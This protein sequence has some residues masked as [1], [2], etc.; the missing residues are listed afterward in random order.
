MWVSVIKAIHGHV[1]NLDHGV[2]VRKSSIWLNCIRCSSNLK[3]RGVDL[4]MC[5]K[6]KVGNG[7][8]SSFWLE[9]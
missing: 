6:K 4:Y 5:M 8:D 1:G 2:K 3:E 7:S 9:N